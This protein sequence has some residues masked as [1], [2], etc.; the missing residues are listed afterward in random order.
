MNVGPS[1]NKEFEFGADH[2]RV[3]DAV[4]ERSHHDPFVPKG[5]VALH[6]QRR[7]KAR[8]GRAE[9]CGKCLEGVENTAQRMEGV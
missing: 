1:E 2:R 9:G 4:P 8:G 7:E 6:L 3:A 5:V